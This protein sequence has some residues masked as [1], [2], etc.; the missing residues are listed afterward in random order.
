VKSWVNTKRETLTLDSISRYFPSTRDGILSR[1]VS[2]RLRHDKSKCLFESVN[3]INDLSDYTREEWTSFCVEHRKFKVVQVENKDNANLKSYAHRVTPPYDGSS[4]ASG[5]RFEFR[6]P[7][8]KSD[9]R[10]SGDLAYFLAFIHR[11]IRQ[12]LTKAWE[13][14]AR[15]YFSDE[16]AT[17]ALA[18]AQEIATW[19]LEF[20]KS[21]WL[22][23]WGLT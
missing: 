21:H 23:K 13:F 9:V 17:L 1:A 7:R 2:L 11:P 5:E 3:A 19:E 22:R 18:V 8:K 6:T 15:W 14:P 20:I 10:R 16:N 4:P 12:Y